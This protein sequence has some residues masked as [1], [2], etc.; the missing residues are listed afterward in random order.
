[1]TETRT[2][3]SGPPRAAYLVLGM[4]RSGTSATAQLLA[5]AGAG[6][7]EHVMPGDQH[8]AK[9][10]FEPWRIANLNNQRL[11]AAGSAWDD[12]FA[13]PQSS[14]PI[15]GEQAWIQQGHD[16]FTEEYGDTPLPLLKDPRVS[17]LMPFWEQVLTRLGIAPRVVIPVRHPLAVAGSLAKRNGFP[18]EKSVLLWTSYMLASEAYSRGLPRVFVSYDNLLAD[19]R[20]QLAR[21]ETAHGIAMPGLTKTGIREMDR[22]LTPKLNHNEA[23]GEMPALD[24]LGPLI[25][26]FHEGLVSAAND[27]DLDG[28]AIAAVADAVSDLKGRV[29]AL[30]SPVT[31][32]LDLVRSQL[33]DLQQKQDFDEHQKVLNDP[34]PRIAALEAELAALRSERA[35]L[36]ALISQALLTT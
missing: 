3:S 30:V 13:F 24:G 11:Q 10:Y 17:V 21:I 28:A 26:A 25:S 12:V 33:L 19:W 34:T 27:R 35:E 16:L 36:E 8:N 29:G 6:L 1:M 2:E 32:D 15:K 5:K 14:L 4:H 18:V 22:F 7:P 31:R 9:G 23:E 20:G